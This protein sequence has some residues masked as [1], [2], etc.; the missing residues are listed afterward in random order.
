MLTIRIY[1]DPVLRKHAR[2]VETFDDDLR[3]FVDEMTGAMRE[4][5]GVGLAAPQVGESM[6]IAVIDPTGGEKPPLVLINPEI[7][8][9]SADTEDS[10][11]GCLSIPEI[12]LKISRP[13]QVTVRAQDGTGATYTIDNAEGLLCR[14][15]Q[16]EIDHLNGIMIVDHVSPL[17]RQMISGRLR[18]MAREQKAGSRTA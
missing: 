13:C 11:E 17:Q 8:A 5:D 2:T 1:G 12:T 10:E 18:K 7:I 16:H 9:S 6:R 14:A 3:R 15:L 4:Y